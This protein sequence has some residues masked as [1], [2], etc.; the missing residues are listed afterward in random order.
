MEAS[1]PTP[2]AAPDP[3]A[4]SNRMAMYILGGL[5][6]IVA[7]VAAVF[8]FG[9]ESKEDKALQAVCDARADIQQRVNSLVT[10]QPSDFTLNGFKEDVAAIQADIKTIQDNEAELGV[11]RKQEV[12]QAS[13]QFVSTIRS[14]AGSLLTSTSINDAQDKLQAAASDLAT[15]YKAALEPID[16]S[17]V[18]APS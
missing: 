8:F 9:K 11:D 18:D 13:Q 15:G 6:I 7:I 14:T 12:Q 2:P 10:T 4:K 16:C 3:V 17:G 5:V 1:A